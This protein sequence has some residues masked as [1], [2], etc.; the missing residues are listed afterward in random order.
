MLCTLE[1]NQSQEV[2]QDNRTISPTG[3][4]DV[5]NDLADPILV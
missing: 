1:S 4:D 3:S 2:C 5:L